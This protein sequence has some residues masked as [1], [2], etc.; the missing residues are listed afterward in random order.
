[1]LDGCLTDFSLS[2]EFVSRASLMKLRGSNWTFCP[3]GSLTSTLMFRW[4]LRPL[5]VIATLQST[6]D[7]VIQE[8][9]IDPKV[10]IPR[11]F[12]WWRV[13]GIRCRLILAGARTQKNIN[14]STSNKTARR[15]KFWIKV[16]M[17][18]RNFV[19]YVDL[20]VVRS[21][22]RVHDSISLPSLV[23]WPRNDQEVFKNRKPL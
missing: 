2:I 9:L 7:T 20:C 22:L 16:T 17:N 6:H 4:K 21:C 3:L 18:F 19:W 5:L 12:V 23:S 15:W 11:E 14:K 10:S 13:N 1:M 8:A